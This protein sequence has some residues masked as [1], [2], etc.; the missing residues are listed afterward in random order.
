MGTLSETLLADDKRGKV[1][2]DSCRLIDGEV[3][4]KSGITGLLI[5]GGYKAFK[6]VKPTM[7][8]EAVTFLL[9]EFV[10]VMD[11]HYAE[12]LAAEPKKEMTLDRWLVRRDTKVADD[13]LGITDRIMDRSNKAALKAIY[14]KLRPV[15]QRNVKEAIP[16]IGRLI[17]SHVK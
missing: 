14:K 10:G 7:V 4:A 2:E 17:A 5:K 6:A 12:Y 3:A 16:G 15:G 1:I 13:L 11:R 9:P 8:H